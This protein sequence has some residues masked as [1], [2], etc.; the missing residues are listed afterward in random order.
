MRRPFQFIARPINKL[1]LAL[2][3]VASALVLLLQQSTMRLSA[4]APLQIALV[5]PFPLTLAAFNLSLSFAFAFFHTQSNETGMTLVLNGHA[6]TALDWNRIATSTVLNLTSYSELSP[7]LFT[8][9]GQSGAEADFLSKT[10]GTALTLTL[11]SFP[12]L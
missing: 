4:L 9:Y 11:T 8:P 7:R 2:L 1:L 12:T 10:I 5:F 6:G 3:L